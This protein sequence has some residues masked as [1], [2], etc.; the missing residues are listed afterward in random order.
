MFLLF[1][2]FPVPSLVISCYKG[3]CMCPRTGSVS[4]P[5]L[6]AEEDW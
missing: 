1:Q 6:G 3:T 2:I 4:T 5:G